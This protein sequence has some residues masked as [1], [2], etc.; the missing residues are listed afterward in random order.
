MQFSMKRMWDMVKHQT[1]NHNF[2][3]ESLWSEKRANWSEN[4]TIEVWIAQKSISIVDPLHHQIFC[5]GFTPPE[6]S[7]MHDN[8]LPSLAPKSFMNWCQGVTFTFFRTG[9]VSWQSSVLFLCLRTQFLFFI[10]PWKY[11]NKE[12]V[13]TYYLDINYYGSC[14]RSQRTIKS[15]RDTKL[16]LLLAPNQ[17]RPHA[18]PK[19]I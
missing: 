2:P 14:S 16:A 4:L 15:A 6:L 3:S 5:G 1:Q 19:P 12:G 7:G 17:T 13:L 8:D 11:Q 10:Q 9:E 18:N